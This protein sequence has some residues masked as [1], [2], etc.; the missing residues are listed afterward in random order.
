M[1]H[2]QYHIKKQDRLTFRISFAQQQACSRFNQLCDATELTPQQPHLDAFGRCSRVGG[3][4]SAPRLQAERGV[5]SVIC[6]DGTMHD[7]GQRGFNKT[8]WGVQHVSQ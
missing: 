6:P 3:L 4:Q 1:R 7:G 5:E 8:R 2:V